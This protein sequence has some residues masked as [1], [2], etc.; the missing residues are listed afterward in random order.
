MNSKSSATWSAGI[1]ILHWLSAIMILALLALGW[2]MV[3]LDYYHAWYHKAP[4]WHRSLG[5]SLIALTLLRLALRSM[6]GRPALKG[7]VWQQC[8][9]KGVHI[10]LYGL[11]VFILVSGVLIA[12]SDGNGIVVVGDL[13]LPS[14]SELSSDWAD[15]L[16]LW[17]HQASVGLLVLIVLHTTAA[18]KHHMIDRDDSLRRMIK[19][20]GA[21]HD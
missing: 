17:H 6:Q 2:W 9:A 5:I 16:G 11:I 12:G 20:T 15:R 18:L 8:L 14:V 3:D 10:A 19:A 4:L 21:N 7:P 1:R 13:T